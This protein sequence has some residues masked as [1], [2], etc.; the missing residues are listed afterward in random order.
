VDLFFFLSFLPLGLYSFLV[1]GTNEEEIKAISK[2]LVSSIID[3]RILVASSFSYIR[4]WLML[5]TVLRSIVLI[6]TLLLGKSET[7]E[8]RTTFFFFP[9][10][11]PAAK[12]G[13]TFG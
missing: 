2:V 12:L 5:Q 7:P 6:M 3:A 8:S 4:L 11:P 1:H 13:V 10:F 9:Q